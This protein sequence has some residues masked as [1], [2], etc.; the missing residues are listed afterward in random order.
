MEQ[1]ISIVGAVLILAAYAAHQYGLL[2][3]THAGYI[4][5]SFHDLKAASNFEAAGVSY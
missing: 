3:R 2:D 5:F 4:P 1:I